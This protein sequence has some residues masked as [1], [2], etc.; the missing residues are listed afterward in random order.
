MYQILLVCE[1]DGHQPEQTIVLLCIGPLKCIAP[2]ASWCTT[3]PGVIWYTRFTRCLRL[4]TAN[5][6]VPHPAPTPAQTPSVPPCLVKA[7]DFYRPINSAK[8]HLQAEVSVRL[9][10]KLSGNTQMFDF[11]VQ[12]SQVVNKMQTL[13]PSCAISK[14]PGEV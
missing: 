1:I 6:W 3:T 13:H 14:M 4:A 9:R 8:G 12:R 7:E 2:G 5:F 11:T 10:Q